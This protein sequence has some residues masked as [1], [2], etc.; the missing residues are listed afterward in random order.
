[1]SAGDAPPFSVRPFRPGDERPL[2]ALFE[3][4]FGR[5]L[6]PA[7]YRWKFIDLPWSSPAPG[8]WVGVV[9]GRIVGHFAGTPV[10]FRIE[11]EEVV[12]MHGADVMTHPAHRGRG[13][14]AAVEAGA[15]RAWREGGVALSYGLHHGAWSA[16]RAPHG[17]RDVFP[18]RWFRRPLTAAAVAERAPRIAAPALAAGLRGWTALAHADLARAARGI[19]VHE[20][21]GEPGDPV[22]A[23]WRRLRDAHP[24]QLVRDRAWVD[25]RYARSPLGRYR[26]FL[27]R[28]AGEPVGFAALRVDGERAELADLFAAPSDGG[29]RAAL[30]LAILD[31]LDAAGARSVRALLPA[32]GPAT[33]ALLRAGFLPARGR[34]ECAALWLRSPALPRALASPA[35]WFTT[36]GDYD[37]V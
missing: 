34:Y 8:A 15:T 18:L 19:A 13:I 12:A 37:L 28:R 30:L 9:E 20:L 35:T 33:A 31:A 36:A 10:R 26:L 2:A 6:A 7:A 21:A 4:V 29:A 11:R 1:M 14:A 3:E 32:R 27:A 5:P 25:H 22:D 16:R 24:A 23:L 17:W